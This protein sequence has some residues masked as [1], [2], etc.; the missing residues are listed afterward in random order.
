MILLTVSALAPR[1]FKTDVNEATESQT[2]ACFT[3]LYLVAVASGG[4]KACIS[5]Y[6]ADQFDDNDKAEK[7]LKSS[8]FNWY[9]QMMNIGSLI[10]HSLIVWVQDN[11][12]WDWGFGIPTL[13]MLMGV[14]SFLS[15][16]WFYRNHKP[17]GSPLTSLFQVVVASLR[18]KRINVQTDASLLYEIADANSSTTGSRQLNHTRNLRSVSY[19]VI[20]VAKWT[21][22]ASG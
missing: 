21:G 4:V 13:A 18:K 2:V 3:A 8:F 9:Y 14:V 19:R 7:K 16:T 20:E 1:W 11:V 10:A 5:A 17:G 12:G 22:W 15:G 6:G